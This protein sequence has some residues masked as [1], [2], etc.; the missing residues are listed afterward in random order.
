[1]TSLVF[2]ELHSEQSKRFKNDLLIAN[3]R[4]PCTKQ[5]GTYAPRVHVL[6]NF[7]L[8]KPLKVV[9]S[10]L[11][12]RSG[13]A[14]D[15]GTFPPRVHLPRGAFRGA[16]GAVMPEEAGSGVLWTNRTLPKTVQLFLWR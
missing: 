12:S 15:H 16:G 14:V 3:S 10:E 9:M 8:K 2:L 13:W 7:C 5:K 11:L 4:L 6:N 1:M